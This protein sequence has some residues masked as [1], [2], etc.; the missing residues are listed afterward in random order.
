M[1]AQKTFLQT[2]YASY[3]HGKHIALDYV[4]TYRSHEYSKF[5]CCLFS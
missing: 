5:V 3:D 1:H 4:L 2:V